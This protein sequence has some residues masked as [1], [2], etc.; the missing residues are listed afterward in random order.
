MDLSLRKLG[1]GNRKELVEDIMQKLN[2]AGGFLEI[3]AKTSAE[4]IN[5][6]FRVSKKQ[7]KV[8]LGYLYKER[9]VTT[10]ESGTRVVK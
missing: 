10:D 2:D 4:D 1:Y 3:N 5:A 6:M 9:L 7:F 8:A